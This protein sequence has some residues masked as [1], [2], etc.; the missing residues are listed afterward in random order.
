MRI[1]TDLRRRVVF[2]LVVAALLVGRPQ[3]AS[4]AKE[5]DWWGWLEEFSAP[6]PFHGF[7]LSAEIMCINLAEK[8]QVPLKELRA[9]I[10]ELVEAGRTLDASLTNLAKAASDFP[11]VTR[12]IGAIRRRLAGTART[13]EPDLPSLLTSIRSRARDAGF[14]VE[15]LNSFLLAYDQGQQ[16]VSQAA[17]A[18][19]IGGAGVPGVGAVEAKTDAPVLGARLEVRKPIL[20]RRPA[21]HRRGSTAGSRADRPAPRC[22]GVACSRREGGPASA[23][24]EADRGAAGLAEQAVLVDA[25]GF[26]SVENQLFDPEGTRDDE[27]QLRIIPLEIL[28]HSKVSSSIDI[29]AGV[30][31]AFF[32]RTDFRNDAPSSNHVGGVLRRA[33]ERRRPHPGTLVHQRALGVDGWLPRPPQIF[34]R[35]RR[36]RLRKS[37][38]HLQTARRVRVGC[39]RVRRP[40]GAVRALS[41]AS[42]W[43]RAS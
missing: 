3:A 38:W 10:P 20:S 41:G 30:G 25:G 24:S 34:R 35:P 43:I 28:A 33:A 17:I 29:G 32:F 21:G 5:Q 4:A 26:W 14:P 6:G 22:R 2:A 8:R 18:S 16:L 42:T 37:C 39:R 9:K 27:P 7:E 36:R 1:E 13:D 23:D 40:R 11:E 15:A 19:M 12:S 31:V